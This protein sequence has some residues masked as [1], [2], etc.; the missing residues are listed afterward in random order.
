MIFLDS[1]NMGIVSSLLF[2]SAYT[3]GSGRNSWTIT[4][5]PATTGDLR[6]VVVGLTAQSMSSSAIPG[7]TRLGED[8]SWYDPGVAV[9]YQVKRP[10]SVDTVT[11]TVSGYGSA[12]TFVG[13]T[14]PSAM[15]PVLFATAKNTSVTSSPHTSPAIMTTKAN[16]LIVR[17]IVGN[18]PAL[19]AAGY[20][21]W[22]APMTELV[23]QQSIAADNA[24]DNST[25]NIATGPA[26][27]IGV[28]PAVNVVPSVSMSYVSATFAIEPL[29]LIAGMHLT[30]QH[31]LVSTSAQTQVAG[32]SADGDSTVTADRLVVPITK[33]GATVEVYLRYQ[34]NTAVGSPS[35]A[36]R[37]LKNS[38]TTLASQSVSGGGAG[39]NYEVVLTYTGNLVAG[40]TLYLTCSGT[41][42]APAPHVIPGV[43]SFVRVF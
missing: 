12:N 7:F 27:D 18:P 16:S 40:D 34:T 10:L 29:V 8:S 41:F 23:Q 20:S 28:Q 37:L 30:T 2:P 21:A 6:I 4:L 42:V 3:S 1:F 11:I 32:W 15:I 24:G 43:D 17:S 38:S 31:N 26:P 13:M 5:P 39:T 35:F 14:I 9:F 22:G 33:T 36:W 25:L 19:P